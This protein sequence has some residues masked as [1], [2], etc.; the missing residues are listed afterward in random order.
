M[1]DLILAQRIK[2]D[3]E[4]ALEELIDKFTPLISAVIA[5]LSKGELSTA[6]I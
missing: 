4:N 2:N 6:D 3:D 5:N 1:D